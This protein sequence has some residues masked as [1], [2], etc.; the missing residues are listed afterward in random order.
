MEKGFL[1]NTCLKQKFHSET[2]KNSKEERKR[3][4]SQGAKPPHKEQNHLCLCI[5]EGRL[6]EGRLHSRGEPA[7]G[8]P[9]ELLLA[10]CGA[11]VGSRLGYGVVW[12]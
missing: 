11:R 4:L 2:K 6:R 10:V 7:R 12:L 8:S 5:C 1:I 3:R 9:E